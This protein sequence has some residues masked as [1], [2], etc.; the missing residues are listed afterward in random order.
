[1]PID[2]RKYPKN[3]KAIALAVKEAAGWQCQKCGKPCRKAGESL[4]DFQYRL[5]KTIS[6]RLAA[7]CLLKP[8]RFTLTVAHWP[9]PDPMNV[10]P[11]NL[12]AWCSVCHLKA[13]AAMHGRNAAATRQRK[14]REQLEAAGQLSLFGGEV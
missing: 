9:D 10:S 13:D 12:H 8:Q 14:K 11:E 6:E 1:M 5:Y 2:Y 3:W 7:E 4:E